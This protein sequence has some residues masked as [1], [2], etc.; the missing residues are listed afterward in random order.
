MWQES[1]RSGEGNVATHYNMLRSPVV[2]GRVCLPVCVCVWSGRGDVMWYVMS[3]TRYCHRLRT[4]P[5]PGH[6]FHDNFGRLSIYRADKLGLPA[7]RALPALMPVIN[8][9][10]Q[11][12]SVWR[13]LFCCVSTFQ[14]VYTLC[15]HRNYANI[16]CKYVYRTVH[17]CVQILQT[18]LTAALLGLE[19]CEKNTS[20]DR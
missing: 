16:V 15:P 20:I 7:L 4:P 2:R 14:V 10:C 13:P 19:L 12:I 18:N 3:F 8:V 1:G 11:L 6:T 17:M 9:F 5:Q